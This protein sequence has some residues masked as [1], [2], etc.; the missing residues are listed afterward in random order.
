MAV[1]VIG[2][3]LSRLTGEK[4]SKQ[5]S[6]VDEGEIGQTKRSIKKTTNLSINKT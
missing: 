1:M 5:K 2:L 4:E 6:H 3:M